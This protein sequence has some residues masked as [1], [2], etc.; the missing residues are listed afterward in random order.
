MCLNANYCREIQIV[1][2]GLVFN[3]SREGKDNMGLSKP[4]ENDGKTYFL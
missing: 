1:K 4:L 2:W 3:N